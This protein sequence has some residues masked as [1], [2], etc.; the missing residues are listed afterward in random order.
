MV[1][2]LNGTNGLDAAPPSSE[3]VSSNLRPL[4]GI[5]VIDLSRLLPG[6]YASM[7]LADFGADVIKV[8]EP[9]IGD[10]ARL[11]SP[12]IDEECAFFKEVNRN[13]RSLSLNLKEPKGLE[14]FYRIIAQADVLLE[15]FRPGVTERLGIDYRRVSEANPAIV[16][17]SI[18]G[19]GHDTP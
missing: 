9:K 4:S 11:M 15:G 18:T 1:D 14:T 10:P 12:K 13:K 17:C 19:Y 16:Y 6:P 5:K 3:S 7:L 2:S 8:E